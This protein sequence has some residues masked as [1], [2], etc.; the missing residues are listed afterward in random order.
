MSTIHSFTTKLSFIS[1]LK[2]TH[3]HYQESTLTQ[4]QIDTQ[5]LLSFALFS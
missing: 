1:S 4:T 2:E 3:F 5:T